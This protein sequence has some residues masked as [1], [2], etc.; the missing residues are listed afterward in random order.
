LFPGA[1]AGQ[2]SGATE[3]G[4]LVLNVTNPQSFAV[5][6]T[7]VTQNGP[8]TVT[9]GSGSPACTGDTQ[10][11]ANSSGGFNISSFGNSGVWVS[12]T[13]PSGTTPTTYT[14]FAPVSAVSVAAGATNVSVTIPNAV[15]MASTSANGCQ[16]ATFTMPVILTISM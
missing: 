8:V 14:T 9:G 16:G 12:A 5:K 4:D 15:S 1:V 10:G 2:A 6:I 3:G 7:G 11:T 13:Q